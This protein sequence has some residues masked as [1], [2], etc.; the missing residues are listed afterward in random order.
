MDFSLLNNTNK[1]KK[2]KFKIENESLIGS[3]NSMPE[4]QTIKTSQ[5]ETNIID[6]TRNN[7]NVNPKKNFRQMDNELLISFNNEII[8]NKNKND[9]QFENIFQLQD[10]QLKN[11][12][13]DIATNEINTK[14][15]FIDEILQIENK[16]R[17]T[18]Q[19][20][21]NF[22]IGYNVNNNN[23]NHSHN[24]NHNNNNIHQTLINFSNEKKKNEKMKNEKKKDNSAIFDFFKN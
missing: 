13:N 21:I 23:N 2:K 20:L 19:D 6:F 9:N 17:E 1:K 16:K 3:I 18:G 15:S 4:K 22:D 8:F 24:H 11:V 12:G 5:T 7:S 10:K 14:Q